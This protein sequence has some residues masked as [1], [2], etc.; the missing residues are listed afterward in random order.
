MYY[1][2]LNAKGQ[3]TLPL[4]V[5]KKLG[6]EPGDK[7]TYEIQMNG[8]FLLGKRKFNASDIS[9]LSQTLIEWTS[10]EDEE[11]YKNL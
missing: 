5:R 2:K 1:S 3:T 11:A 6:L 4:A 8:S 9:A 7:I 10:A